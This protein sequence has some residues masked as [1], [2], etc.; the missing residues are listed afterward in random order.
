MVMCHKTAAADAF[1]TVAI[2]YYWLPYTCSMKSIFSE[3]LR[4]SIA[5]S[6]TYKALFWRYLK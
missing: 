3:Q 2:T 4:T 5:V 6:H 1:C